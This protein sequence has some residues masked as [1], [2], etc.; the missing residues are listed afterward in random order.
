MV[1]YDGLRAV[2]GLKKDAEKTVCWGL[3]TRIEL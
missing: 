1:L 2:N 3:I